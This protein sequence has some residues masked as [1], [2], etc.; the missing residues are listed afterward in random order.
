MDLTGTESFKFLIIAKMSD[1]FEFL[2]IV[3]MS[4]DQNVLNQNV[5]NSLPNKVFNL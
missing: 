2:V 3:E 1:S 5:W 4:I